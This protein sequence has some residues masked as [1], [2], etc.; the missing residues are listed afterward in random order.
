MTKLSSGVLIA[1]GVIVL[2]FSLFMNEFQ[3]KG[4]FILFI[5]AGFFIIIWGLLKIPKKKKEQKVQKIQRI[6]IKYCKNCG[7]PMHISDKFCRRCGAPS[8]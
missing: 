1:I 8:R 7:A 3:L 5:F 2:F 4:R 6:D